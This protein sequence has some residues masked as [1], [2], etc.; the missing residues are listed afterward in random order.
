[1][2]PKGLKKIKENYYKVFFEFKGSGAGAPGSIRAEQFNIDLA[3]DENKG[4]L[5]CWGYNIDSPMKQR[6]FIA[7]PSE[8]Y[9]YFSPKEDKNKIIK[10]IIKTLMTY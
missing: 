3:F 8:W 7:Q 4:L 5:K 1:M 9:E 6:L 2:F 10:C